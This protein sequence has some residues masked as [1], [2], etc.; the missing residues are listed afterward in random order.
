MEDM[1]DVLRWGRTDDMVD[2][3][4]V[5]KEYFKVDVSAL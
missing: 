4:K 1:K 2:G 5:G 3:L